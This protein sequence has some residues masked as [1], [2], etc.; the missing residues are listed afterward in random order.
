MKRAVYW[1]EIRTGKDGLE[2][3][4]RI[5]GLST[6]DLESYPMVVLTSVSE[7]AL[8]ELFCLCRTK[9]IAEAISFAMNQTK[10]PGELDL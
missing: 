7:S 5:Y 8:G 1:P 3:G 2:S 4:T 6:V 9:R 10:F